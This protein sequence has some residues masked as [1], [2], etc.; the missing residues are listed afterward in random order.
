MVL[1]KICKLQLIIFYQFYPPIATSLQRIIRG[2]Y[3]Y[4][5]KNFGGTQLE[6]FELFRQTEMSICIGINFFSA[7]R[8]PCDTTFHAM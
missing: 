3:L 7:M 4:Y 2:I 1:V 6:N 8:I 5:N